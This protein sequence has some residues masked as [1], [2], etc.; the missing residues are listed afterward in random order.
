MWLCLL[1]VI[2]ILVFQGGSLDKG[3]TLDLV[4]FL[5]NL[6]SFEDQ[7]KR[8]GEFIQEIK[9]QLYNFQKERELWV[10]FEV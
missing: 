7:L 5:N 8:R 10:K 9:K 2:L 4:V 1:P 3:S 6:T